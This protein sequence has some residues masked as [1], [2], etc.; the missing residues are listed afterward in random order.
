[1]ISTVG[2]HKPLSVADPREVRLQVRR[3]SAYSAIEEV[4]SPQRGI[5]KWKLLSVGLD[6]P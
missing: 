4:D 2:I 6:K 5:A 3:V 1:V